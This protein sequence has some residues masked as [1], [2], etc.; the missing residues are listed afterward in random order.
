MTG[1]AWMYVFAFGGILA[2]AIAAGGQFLVL[3]VILPVMRRWPVS[4]S[5]KTHQAM[6]DTLPDRY[7]PLCTGASL[8]AAIALLALHDHLPATSTGLIALG[9]LGT[10]G[11]LVISVAV[12]RPSSKV[13][14]GWSPETVPEDYRQLRDRWDRMH[15]LRTFLGTAAL[16]CYLTAGLVL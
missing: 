14:A 2:A 1:S 5:V 15:A 3:L 6:L 4:L 11:V 13:I 9:V 8:A 16:V 12:T 10:V 7:L